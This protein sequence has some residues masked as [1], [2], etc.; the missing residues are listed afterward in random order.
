MAAN[1]EQT[2]AQLQ[3]D[4]AQLKLQNVR[5][6]ALFSEELAKAF[7]ANTALKAELK[8]KDNEFALVMARRDNEH[9]GKDA[10]ILHELLATKDQCQDLIAENKKM[11][12]QMKALETDNAKLHEKLA[13]AE[14]N[15][16]D[17]LTGGKP[18][19]EKSLVKSF[20]RPTHDDEHSLVKSFGRPMLD[21]E[22]SLAAS[23]G[24][25][26]HKDDRHTHREK[27]VASGTLDR[28]LQ[29]SLRE[30]P[31]FMPGFGTS[32]NHS[33]WQSEDWRIKDSEF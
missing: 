6:R 31:N 7:E 3:L 4:I 24:R 28:D 5:D 9:A 30:A 23:F 15:L 27:R 16:N 17:V 8:K 26:T 1:D 20:D 2:I 32:R 21:D 10:E 18:A 13:E 33:D 14:A 25:L 22:H 29:R 12:W 11:A 19:N